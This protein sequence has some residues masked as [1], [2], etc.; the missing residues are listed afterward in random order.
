MRR[1]SLGL[2]FAAGAAVF[3]VILVLYLPAAWLAGALPADVRC[4]ELGGSVWHGECLGLK[5]ADVALGDA[6]WNLGI[7]SAITG[8]LVGAFDVRG[9]AFNARAEVDASFRGSGVLRNIHANLNLDPGLIAQ[10]PPDKRGTVTVNLGRLEVVDGAPRAIEGT[11][12]VR[13]FRQVGARPFELGSYQAAFDG[14][15][16]SGPEGPLVG[17]LRDLGGP[18]AIEGTITLTPPRNYV[19]Q[20][21]ITGRT[22]D[23]ERLVRREIALGAMPD[24]A[25]RSEFSFEGSY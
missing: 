22:A 25:G 15:S 17:K 10:L 8:R 16:S 13:D 9:S 12:E 14:N 4:G 20:G 2:T 18:F 19:V 21:F 23:S 3:L 5:Y 24:A 11:I 7:G 1:R 6:T